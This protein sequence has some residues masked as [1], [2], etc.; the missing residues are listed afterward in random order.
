MPTCPIVS[1][2]RG[3]PDTWG[4]TLDDIRAWDHA[5]LESQHDF[6]QFLF[7]LRE[8]SAVVAEAPLV[9]DQTVAAFAADPTLRANLA[10]SLNV[11]LDFYGLRHD[12]SAERIER[13]DFFPRRAQMWLTPRNHN[14]LRL[15]RILTSL[16]LLGLPDRSAALLTCLEGIAVEFPQVVGDSARYWRATA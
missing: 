5:R 13:S 7:P 11:M 8:P 6:I 2:Y 15:T 4:R 14:F 12:H 1:F 16:R 9:T 3:G 10:A